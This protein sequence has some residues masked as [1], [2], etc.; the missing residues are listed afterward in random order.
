M[1]F[2]VRA[3][4]S[5]PFWPLALAALLSCGR[6]E[7]APPR[8]EPEA[9]RTLAALADGTTSVRLSWTAPEPGAGG[10]L[11]QYDLRFAT[12]PL[13][14]A[15]FDSAEAATAP[16]PAEPSELQE[17]RLAGLDPATTVQRHPVLRT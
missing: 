9:V 4:Q 13:T 2:R 17:F 12:A 8:E 5:R 7:P 15:S 1:P 14:E 6:E 3:A 10:D 11:L 16:D